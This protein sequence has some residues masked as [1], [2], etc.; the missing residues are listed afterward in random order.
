MTPKTVGAWFRREDYAAIKALSPGE[1]NLPDTFD[2]WNEIATK[3][4]AEMESNGIVV[5]KVIIVP[6]EFAQW[7]KAR[8]VK[9][10]GPSRARFAIEK[11]A[12]QQ[13]GT[14]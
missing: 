5:E 13:K 10:D 3:Q 14:A 11:D 1:Y 8:N 7:C 12:T 9:P 4:V 6:Q 2:E